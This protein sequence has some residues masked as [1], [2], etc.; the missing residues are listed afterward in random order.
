[1]NGSGNGHPNGFITG[2][3]NGYQ[4]ADTSEL[5]NDAPHQVH[6]VTYGYNTEEGY[7]NLAD[8]FTVDAPTG[9]SISSFTFWA[10]QTGWPE[11]TTNPITSIR[12]RLWD[13]DPSQPGSNIVAAFSSNILDTV[14]ST[15]IN[16]YRVGD[17]SVGDDV[18]DNQRPIFSVVADATT[19]PDL[20]NPLPQGTYWVEWT[21]VGSPF[22][23]GPFNMPTVPHNAL[24]DG[25]VQYNVEYDQWN[26]VMDN[27]PGTIGPQ[28]LAFQ[29]D[30]AIGAAATRPIVQPTPVN[31]GVTLT[32]IL[33]ASATTSPMILTPTTSELVGQS[34]LT[35]AAPTAPNASQLDSSQLDLLYSTTGG[36]HDKGMP[37][38]TLAASPDSVDGLV[39][40]SASTIVPLI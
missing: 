23:D 39:Q 29:I 13:N 11:P 22:Y 34:A 1:L 24:T 4:M 32:N 18:M 2:M 36:S 19:W 37:V 35:R 20:P 21:M 17:S 15:F 25:A 14:N 28:D 7:F 9:W 3:G 30:G 33:A 31:P 12:L 26:P 40:T 5:E 38:A 8:D 16:A 27:P 6:A 10:Y